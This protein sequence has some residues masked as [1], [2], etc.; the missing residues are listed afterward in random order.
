[1]NNAPHQV[2]IRTIRDNARIHHGIAEWKLKKMKHGLRY[3][4]VTQDN[5]SGQ[6]IILPDGTSQLTLERQPGRDEVNFAEVV[7]VVDLL[8][9]SMLR[10]IVDHM[11]LM[12][13]ISRAPTTSRR[14]N[15]SSAVG[16]ATTKRKGRW[17]KPMR[18][19]K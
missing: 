10:D 1:M 2:A 7:R 16:H 15:R 14:S 13:E 5:R 17:I 4:V 6:F 3:R 8:P 9:P 18:R 19:R 11:G 12:L